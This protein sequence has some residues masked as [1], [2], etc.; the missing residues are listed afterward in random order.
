M[1]YVQSG[2][3][4]CPNWEDPQVPGRGNPQLERCLQLFFT[5]TDSTTGKPNGPPGRVDWYD[6]RLRDWYKM[7]IDK[8][9]GGAQWSEIYVFNEDSSAGITAAKEMRTATGDL[10]GVFGKS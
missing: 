7:I 9:E 6:P 3:A 2:N 5:T 1:L 4:S 10:L 8:G